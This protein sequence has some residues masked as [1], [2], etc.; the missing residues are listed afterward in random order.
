MK[1]LN[2]WQFSDAVVEVL[3]QESAPLTRVVTLSAAR[4]ASQTLASPI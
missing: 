4:L 2:V 3:G 1:E